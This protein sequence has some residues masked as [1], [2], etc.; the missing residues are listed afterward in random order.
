MDGSLV[1]SLEN[2]LVV[3]MVDVKV[4][5]S[6]ANLVVDL[7]GKRVV[8]SDGLMAGY[9]DAELVMMSAETMVEKSEYH[10]VYLLVDWKVVLMESLSEEMTVLRRN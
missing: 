7:V 6:V 10:R 5:H 1:G 8:L 3:K 4:E 9:L 2:Q